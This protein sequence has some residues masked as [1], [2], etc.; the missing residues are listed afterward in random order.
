MRNKIALFAG[1]FLL[2]AVASRAGA[3]T[4]CYDWDCNETTHVCSFDSSCSSWTG[5]LFRFSW[6]FGDGNSANTASS[7]ITHSYSI[8]YPTVQLTVIPLSSG[9]ASVSCGIVVWNNI[10]P[11][12]GTSGHCP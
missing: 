7:T 11:P 4:A 2:M 3:T 1:C 12:V 8:P 6:D 9:T 5:N 10:G